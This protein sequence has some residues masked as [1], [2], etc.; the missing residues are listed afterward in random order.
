MRLATA[1]DIEIDEIS[2]RLADEAREYFLGTR[3]G[4][5]TMELIDQQRRRLEETEADQFA[6]AELP[7]P[8]EVTAVIRRL[9]LL[10]EAD[11]EKAIEKAKAILSLLEFTIPSAEQWSAPVQVD[12]QHQEEVDQLTA[13]AEA[14]RDREKQNP[15]KNLRV[16]GQ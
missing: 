8:K 4:R 9:Q 12:P 5:Q 2:P 1:M 11:E 3:N 7:R 10:L 14:R 13:Q 6:F 15:G 16:S